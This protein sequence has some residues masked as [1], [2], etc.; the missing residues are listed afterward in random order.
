M[1]LTLAKKAGLKT[2]FWTLEHV[3]QKPVL[4]LRRFDRKQNLR[5]P[6]LSAMSFL[7]ATDGEQSSYQNLAYTLLQNSSF[8]TEDL[9]QLWRLAIFNLMISNT[10]NH[11]RNHGFLYESERG[12]RLAPAYDLNPTPLE[13]KPRFFQTPFTKTTSS[14]SL[15]LALSIRKDFRLPEKKAFDIIKQ[16]ASAVKKWRQ[17][18]S[19]LGLSK[20][21]CDYMK[22]SFENEDLKSVLS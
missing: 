10:D 21:E 16:V 14:N 22:R 7:G 11:L 1:A 19:S 13:I 12:W 18:A 17:V 2:P 8:L 9:E 3:L 4:V 5:I 6:F 20:K 15:E